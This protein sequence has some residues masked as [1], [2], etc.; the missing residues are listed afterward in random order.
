MIRFHSDAFARLFIGAGLLATLGAG[1]GC[2]APQ[3]SPEPKAPLQAPPSSARSVEAG[4]LRVEEARVEL[5]GEMGAAFFT[6]HNSGAEPER[7]LRVE[8]PAAASVETHETV[9]DGSVMRMEPREE[10]F[11]IP[12]GEVLRLEPGGKHAMLMGL[13]EAPAAADSFQLRLIFERQGAVEVSASVGGL[14][15]P[16]SQEGPATEEGGA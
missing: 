3:A 15:K 6:V 11:P 13:A 2:G 16:A 7:L 10:G 4:D 12:P 8:A 5:F 14:M 1:I 9:A